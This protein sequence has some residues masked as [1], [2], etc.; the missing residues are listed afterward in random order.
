[1][2]KALRRIMDTFRGSGSASV[3]IPPM[4][5]ALEPNTLLED[6]P[7]A[8]TSVAPDNLI[9]VQGKIFFSE[10]ST[11]CT[12]DCQDGSL[13][14]KV[15]HRFSSS[16]TALAGWPSGGMAVA[17]ADGTLRIQGGLFN[18]VQVDKLDGVHCKNISAMAFENEASLLVCL[19]SATYAADAWQRDLLQWGATGSVWRIDLAQQ[20]SHCVA[21]GLAYPYG[22]TPTANG[23]MV[24]S[25]AWRHRLLRLSDGGTQAVVLDHLPGYPARLSGAPGGGWWLSV[26][27]P[28]NQLVEFVLRE[29]EFRE[30][31]MLEVKLEHWIVPTL[32]PAGTFLEPLQG[33]ELKQLGKL[34]P[35]AP[36]RSYGLAILLDKDFQP[37]RSIHSRANGRRHGVTSCLASG[38]MLWVT[39]R[40]G[41]AVVGVDLS[42]IQEHQL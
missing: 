4:D 40:G 30:K 22:I 17:L 18:G 34:K 3:S 39:S 41:D 27:A 33:G 35:W 21:K 28:R 15:V 25:E 26:F 24:V 5:G 42:H 16:V 19:G 31:M 12:L 36:T 10:N 20:K 37:V 13:H 9:E 11:V 6:A 29:N 1:M 23:S 2:I 38:D 14:S 32:A 8:L 7:L